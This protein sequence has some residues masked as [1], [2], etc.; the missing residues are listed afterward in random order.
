[1]TLHFSLKSSFRE[2]KSGEGISHFKTVTLEKRKLLRC[3]STYAKCEVPL[4]LWHEVFPSAQTLGSWVR[5]KGIECYLHLFC[6]CVILLGSGLTTGWSP[7][8]GFLPT[9]YMIK[10]QENSGQGS[11]W[12]ASPTDYYYHRNFSHSEIIL[13]TMCAYSEAERGNH[14]VFVVPPFPVE[15]MSD[16]LHQLY[17]LRPRPFCKA[18]RDGFLVVVTVQESWL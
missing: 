9:V 18:R 8:Q 2:K 3:Y 7:T 14:D 4:G 1:M 5:V 11:S 10:K 15:V 6:V 12:S 16:F 13:W 17:W